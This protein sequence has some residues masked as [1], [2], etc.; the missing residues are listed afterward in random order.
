MKLHSFFP[1]C[2]M[3][4]RLLSTNVDI[5]VCKEVYIAMTQGISPYDCNGRHW[6]DRLVDEEQNPTNGLTRDAA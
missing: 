3:K 2:C 1:H 4:I 5:I 6:E